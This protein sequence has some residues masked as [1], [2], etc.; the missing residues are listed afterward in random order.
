[1]HLST[2]VSA[3]DAV[4]ATRSR[5][6]KVERLAACLRRLAPAEI[7]PGVSYLMGTLPQGRIGLGQALLRK[8]GVEP[9]GAAELSVGEADQAF[10]RLSQVKGAGA[11]AQRMQLLT[12]LFRKADGAV[13]DFL[14]RLVLGELRQGALEGL[15]IDAIAKAA[16]QPVAAVRRAV[17]LAGD[18]AAVAQQALLHGAA[19]LAQFRFVL[20]RPLQ[21]MLAQPA[22]D[23]GEVLARLGEAAL[24]YKLDG[25]RVQV[26][27]RDEEVRVFTRQLHDVTASV[28]ELVEQVSSLPVVSLVLDGE[29]IALDPAGRP[30]PFQ[31]T[32]Q[33]F[34]RRRNVA[35]MRDRIPLSAVYFDCL[36]RDGD[37]FIDR[38]DPARSAALQD[39]VPATARVPRLITRRQDAAEAFLQQALAAGHEGIMAKSLSA[40]YQA[41]SRG[42]DWCKIKPSHT[43]DLLVLAAEWGS[44][45]RQGRLSNLHLGAR[46]PASNGFVMLGKTFKGLTD[47]ML[48]WQTEALL[49]REIGREDAVVHVRP[50]LVVEVAFNELQRSRQYPAGMALRFARVKRYRDDKAACEADTLATVREL[51]DARLAGE[52][53]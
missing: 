16:D 27:K 50:E 18:P 42:A 12:A 6:D 26:H 47:A 34:G 20:F 24:E 36:Y 22:Q 46:D 53:P 35:E 49:A 39:I 45:R 31:V 28:P 25:A 21:P 2:L 23:A 30:L 10:E 29:A 19:G 9:A 40:A 13:Q 43:L 4:G 51:F 37:V 8:L 14:V 41:G 5:L 7:R 52:S 11:H 38:P 3:S 48:D 33:R 44:G 1:M 15:M 17:M 32:M